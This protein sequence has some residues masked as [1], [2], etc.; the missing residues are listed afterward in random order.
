[1]SNQVYKYHL[2]WQDDISSLPCSK[3]VISVTEHL[4]E[5]VHF[6]QMFCYRGYQLTTRFNQEN[7]KSTSNQFFDVS[8]PL[9]LETDTFRIGLRVRLL[10]VRDGMNCRN[11]E[12]TD[13]A[14]LWLA[15]FGSKT[16][17]SVE[18]C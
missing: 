7:E 11:D 18:W 1:M 10:Q 13:N 12:I 17:S 5:V 6:N 14:I 16:L 9:Y 3:L 4:V 2:L 15:A 8:R